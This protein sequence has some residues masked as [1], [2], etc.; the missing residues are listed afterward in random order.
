MINSRF[1]SLVIMWKL[2][3]N[4]QNKKQL[5][6]IDVYYNAYHH[7]CGTYFCVHVSVQ[8]DWLIFPIAPWF[9]C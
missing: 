1:I 3:A 8:Q 4:L 6:Y 5:N 7:T 9:E 2:H